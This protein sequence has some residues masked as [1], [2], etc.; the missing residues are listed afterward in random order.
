MHVT[1][2]FHQQLLW[3]QRQCDFLSFP[4]EAERGRGLF[5]RA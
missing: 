4:P 2:L 1:E 3:P 5:I